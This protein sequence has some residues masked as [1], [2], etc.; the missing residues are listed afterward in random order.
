MLSKKQ[1]EILLS[2]LKEIPN[3]KPELEQYTIPGNI[4]ADIINLAHLSGDIENKNVL[5][6]GCGSG[7]LAIG[8]LLMGAKSVTAVDID[9]S[10]L[11]AAKD[12]VKLA[13][14][15]SKK[16]LTDKI[17][18]VC[19]DVSKFKGKADTVIQNPP[20]GIQKEHADRVFLEK[21]LECGQTVYSLHRS[22]HKTRNF[23]QKFVEQKSGKVEK[24]IRFKFRIPYMFKFHQKASVAYDVDLFVISR[25]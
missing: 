3:P 13:E 19:S 20:F 10:V 7:R 6:L 11:E 12:N 21:A 25:V 16:K 14:E 1:L 8:S 4:A 22:F 24:I 15:L 23:I 9:E 18:F 5:D 2:K 17:K